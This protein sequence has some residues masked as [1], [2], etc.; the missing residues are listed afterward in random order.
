M[1]GFG[2]VALDYPGIVAFERHAR[3]ALAAAEEAG[4]VPASDAAYERRVQFAEWRLHAYRG[5]TTLAAQIEGRPRSIVQFRIGKKRNGS[6]G[7]Y[8]N[9]PIFYTLPSW[10]GQGLASNLIEI[11]KRDALDAGA[12]RIVSAAGTWAGVLQHLRSWHLP[13]GLNG[14]GELVFDTALAPGPVPAVLRGEV[15]PGA[16][17]RVLNPRHLWDL[18]DLLEV[19]RASPVYDVPADAREQ[20]R[21][22]GAR[23]RARRAAAPAI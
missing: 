6:W 11:V 8:L 21:L 14:R 22:A 16:A 13:W 10:R 19:V 3:A 5:C 12:S 23:A 15:P 1:T 4:L 18:D 17:A 9:V 20:L 2:L 7:R